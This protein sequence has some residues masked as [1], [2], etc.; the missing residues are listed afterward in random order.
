MHRLFLL[1]PSWLLGEGVLTIM[2]SVVNKCFLLDE[3]PGRGCK[4]KESR[5]YMSESICQKVYVHR[6]FLLGPS[7]LLGEGGIV[8]Y[9]FSSEQMLPFG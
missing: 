2:G 5:K 3:L 9:G 7:W 4:G 1:G 6:L 8:Y